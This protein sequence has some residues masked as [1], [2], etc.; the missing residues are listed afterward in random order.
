MSAGGW[1]ELSN[2]MPYRIGPCEC[3]EAAT[4]VLDGL[5]VSRQ[6]LCDE[7]A[8]V[9]AAE[10]WAKLNDT[11]TSLGYRLERTESGYAVVPANGGVS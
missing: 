2:P 5:L 6:F 8:T 4:H 3:G 10:S 9:A 7:H 1:L 11:V